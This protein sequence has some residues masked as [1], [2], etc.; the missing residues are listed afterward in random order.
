MNDSSLPALEYYLVEVGHEGLND[1]SS[2][3]YVRLMKDNVDIV[4]VTGC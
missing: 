3:P 2:L 4:I 1:V